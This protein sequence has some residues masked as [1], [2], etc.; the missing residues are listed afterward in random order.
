M[1]VLGIS[2]LDKDSTVTLMQDGKVV[3]AAGEERF[4]RKKLQDGFP[5]K[6]LEAGLQYT[7]ISVNDIDAVAYPFLTGKKKQNCSRRIFMMKG[8]SWTKHQ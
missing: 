5:I 8:F 3:F 2:P 4:T 7:G 1:I 6:A